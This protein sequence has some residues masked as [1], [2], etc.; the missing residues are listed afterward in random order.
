MALTE[1]PVE[2]SSTPG[3]A[4]SSNATAITIDSSEQVG[5]GVS[6][7]FP[8]HTS[9]TDSIAAVIDSDNDSGTF[10]YIRNSDATTGRTANLAFAPANNVE[11]ARIAAEA[12]EDFSSSANRT[13]DLV[14]QTRKD[15]TLAEKMRLNAS[16]LLD[17]QG[18][19]LMESARLSTNDGTTYWDL[20]RDSSSGDLVISDDGLGDVI[21]VDQ[22]GGGVTMTRSDNGA[23]LTLKSTDTDASLGPILDLTRD[24]SSAADGDVTGTIRFKADDSVNAQTTYAQLVS[25]ITD[26]SNG[27]EDG[28]FHIETIVSGSTTEVMSFVGGLVFIGKTASSLANTGVE[29]HQNG[30]MY[31][32][33]TDNPQ[34]YLNREN[35]H[36]VQLQGRMDN[37]NVWSI[38]SN[39]NSLASDRNFKKDIADLQLGL[40]FVKE[41]KPKTFRFKMD[42]ETDPLMTGLIAQ[43]LEQSLTD[44]GVEK[45]S[46]TL[47]QHEP[48]EDESESQYMVDYSK[49][50]PVLIKGMQEQ[51][52]LIETLQTKVKALEEA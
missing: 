38:S 10:V 29:I 20:R 17:V 43:D 14:F 50:I 26:A 30:I 44:A 47:V 6:P 45:N 3:I 5:I 2:L 49:L 27:T 31:A 22:A 12:M 37:S 48:Q 15:G 1:I 36:G 52:A 9:S 35:T 16:G 32:T 28:S 51:Q 34:C 23:G 19:V 42:K 24:N 7:S 25:K 46:M 21:T 8:F 13:A 4:D 40:D 39:A 11:G 18:T 33:S 41:L